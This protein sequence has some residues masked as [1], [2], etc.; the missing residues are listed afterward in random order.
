MPAGGLGIGAASALMFLLSACAGVGSS[1]APTATTSD[2]VAGL[3]AYVIG[4]DF[5]VGRN[6]F[7]FTLSDHN[8]PVPNAKP[9]V[10]FFSLH[11]FNALPAGHG[12]AVFQ[13]VGSSSGGGN[14]T[15]I[16]VI[17]TT[18]DRAGKWGAEIDLAGKGGK[19]SL[20]SI[21]DVTRKS[22]TPQIGS[23]APRSQNPTVAQEAITHLDS[24]HP[25]DDMHAI[26]IATAIARHSPLVVLFASAAYCGTFQCGAEIAAVQRVEQQYR[27]RASFVHIDTFRN[28]RPPHLSAP[29]AQWHIPSQP[30][31]F[32]VD[33][34]GIVVAKFEGPA[35]SSELAGAIR[36]V[37]R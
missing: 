5:S 2:H 1:A 35:S 17:N 15:G 30:W 36:R 22:I 33:R 8:R 4:T 26:S 28:A 12:P 27:T 9:T 34:R 20:Q 18:F 10:Y 7:T 37:L 16:Y 3:Q 6:R 11:G 29:A 25:P 19:H 14:E 21:F 32:V 31:V 23:A 13:T 24:G